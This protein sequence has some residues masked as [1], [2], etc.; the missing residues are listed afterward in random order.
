MLRAAASNLHKVGPALLAHWD[1]TRLPLASTSVDRVI[2]NPPFGK[3]ISTPEEIGPLYRGAVR[4]CHRVLKP[5]GRAVFLVSEPDALRNA[6]KVHHWQPSRELRVEVLG[7][8]ATIGVW[9]SRAGTV[10]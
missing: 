4:E 10:Q 8:P 5:G 2:C 7:Q 6:V 1:A 3:Q 9:R